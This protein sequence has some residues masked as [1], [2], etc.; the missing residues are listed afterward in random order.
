MVIDT[1]I[2][3]IPVILKYDLVKEKP[4]T[5]LSMTSL[6]VSEFDILC[7]YFNEILKKQ[8]VEN[9][10]TNKGGRPS[11][12]DLAQDKLF[13]IL[14][15]LKNY[16]LQETIGFMF[17]LS[18]SRANYW[19]HFLSNVLKNT[20]EINKFMPERIQSE[21]LDKLNSEGTQDL[22]VDGTERRINRPQDNE[23]Q[24]Q[25]YSGKKRLIR[26]KI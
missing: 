8:K 12:L 19:I 7:G 16:P 6:T 24:K 15:Y 11:V 2:E 21:L 26:L 18:Q 1:E 14:F 5:F 22:T 25:C 3:T 4:E 10:A 20:L 13:F 17:G 23:K 9:N